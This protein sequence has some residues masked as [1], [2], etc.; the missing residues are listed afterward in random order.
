MNDALLLHLRIVGVAMLLLVVMNI[1]DVPR[2]FRWKQEMATLSLLNRQ[3]FQV[4]AA[5]ICII[6]TMFAA[7][8]LL[9]PHELLAAT[10]LSRAVVAGMAVFWFLR[11]LTQWFIYDWRIWRGN[12]FYTTMHFFFTGLWIYF[13]LTFTCAFAAK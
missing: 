1:F 3:V 13:T 2:R 5:F 11:L 10:K 4:H 9:L 12:R 6:L 7:L 8:T